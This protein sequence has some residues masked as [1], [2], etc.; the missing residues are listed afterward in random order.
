MFAHLNGTAEPAR[1]DR[2][3]A[4]VGMSEA[5]S[6]TEAGRQAAATALRELA[7]EE[8]AIV[9]VFASVSYDLPALLTGVR[10]VTGDAPLAGAS[11]S[12][13]FANG[14]VRPPG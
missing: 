9:L 2:V 1:K 3:R 7:G 4:G 13:Y 11:S 6:A 14:V 10:S 12:G 5:E 8:P